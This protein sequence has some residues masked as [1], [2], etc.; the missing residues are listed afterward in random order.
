[1]TRT[2]QFSVI[3]LFTG[4]MGLDQGL[5]RTGKY[6]LLACV[7]KEHTFCETIRHNQRAGR[8]AKEVKVFEGDISNLDPAQV[9]EAVGIKPGE[10]DLLVGGPPCQSF[11]TAGRRGTVQ[12]TRGTLLWQFLRFVEAM[13]PRFFLMENVRGLLSAA[14][15]HRPIAER[16]ERGGPP[17]GPDE[18]PGSVIRR[19]AEDLQAIPGHS[20]YMDCF[21]VNAVNYGAPQLRERALFIGNRFNETVDFPDPT[22]G[23]PNGLD[24]TPRTL[25]DPPSATLQPWRTLGEAIADLQELNP[26]VL[27]F[28]PRKKHY[29]SLVP[30]GS[31]WRSLP[32][33]LQKESMGLAW[34]AKGGRSGWWRRLTFDLPCPTLV[35]MPNHASTSLCHPTLTRA[36]SIREYSRIQ[37]FPDDWEFCGTTSEQYAQ[38]GNAV[39]V[40]LGLVAGNVIADALDKLAK[41][42]FTPNGRSKQPYRIVYVQSHVRTRQWY[43]DGET[44]IWEDGQDNGSANYAAPKTKRRSGLLKT[45]KLAKG[46]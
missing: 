21:E 44:F 24:E 1:M 16:P 19:F 34:F 36:L 6:R 27:D 39:P 11:S 42:G 30:T 13:K 28:S 29:L 46:L 5:E 25:F 15:Q 35:T 43:K 40:R 32:V 10:L 9:M 41:R 4:G 3:S 2:K 17:L 33:E 45:H 22:H 8:L 38:V 20:Y 37:E 7:E 23:N 14:I 26:I 18:Q 12:D 31:N